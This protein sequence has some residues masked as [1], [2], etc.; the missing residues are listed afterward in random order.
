MVVV[1]DHHLYEIVLGPYLA[2]CA[3]SPCS[4][5]SSS[6]ARAEEGAEGGQVTATPFLDEAGHVRLGAYE[7]QGEGSEGL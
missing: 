1:P 4:C 5:L 7:D 2:L 3:C 6:Y